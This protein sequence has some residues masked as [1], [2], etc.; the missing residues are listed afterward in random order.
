L[1]NFDILIVIL[2]IHGNSSSKKERESWRK[3]EREGKWLVK[4][5]VKIFE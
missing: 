2:N 3:E 5:S 1:E 4:K